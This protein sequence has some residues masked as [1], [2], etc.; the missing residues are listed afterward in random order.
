[1][2]NGGDKS[3]T[4][5]FFEHKIT[6]NLLMKMLGHHSEKVTAHYLRLEDDDYSEQLNKLI[7]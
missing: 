3:T 5:Y 2:T 1:V 4:I 6:I 7:S